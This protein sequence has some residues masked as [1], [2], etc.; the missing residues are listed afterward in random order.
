MRTS[1]TEIATEASLLCMYRKPK[2]WYLWS[3]P[4]VALASTFADTRA[5][6]TAATM[7]GVTLADLGLMQPAILNTADP[8]LALDVNID[9]ST[10]NTE[11][12]WLTFELHAAVT[13]E[14]ERALS[15]S[16]GTNFTL[17]ASISGG[18]AVQ[19]VFETSPDHIEARG[20][21]VRQ[22]QGTGGAP[23]TWGHL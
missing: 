3:I 12:V 18:T 16:E 10:P 19:I 21:V 9:S 14:R 7:E 6:A 20:G 22:L 2:I 11:G 17:S 23:V 13:Y 4:I 1:T 15:D 8:L 5:D